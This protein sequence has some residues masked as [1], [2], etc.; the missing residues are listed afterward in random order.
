MPRYVPGVGNLQPKLMIIGES[1]GAKEDEL[2]LPFQGPSGALLDEALFEAGIRRSDCYITNVVKY[3]PPL[4][5]VKKYH[6]AGI[7][8][9][10]CIKELWENE[11]HI[12]RPNCILAI[13]DLALSAVTG[14]TGILLYRGSILHSRDGDFK[15]VPTIH[16][17]AL[18]SRAKSNE[19]D[20]DQS[21][22][23]SW[24]WWKIIKAD[25][26]R[27]VEES[28]TSEFNLPNRTLQVIH[29]SLDLYRF[30]REYEGLTDCTIDIE[31]I[32]CVPSCIGFAFNRHHAVSVPLLTHIGPHKLTDMGKH[33]MNEIWRIVDTQLRKLQLSGHNLMYDDYKLG[34]IGMQLTNVK[35]DT[36][37]K[38]RVIFPELP[39]KK[40]HVVSSIWTREPFYKDEG[41]EFKLGKS[42]ISQHLL[43]NAKDC[44]VEREVDEEQEKDLIL[45][46]ECYRVPARDYY[47]K[48]QMKKHK[49]YLKMSNTGFR[50]D[51]IKRSELRKRYTEMQNEVHAKLVADIGQEINV[52]SYPQVYELL[53]KIMKLRVMKKDPT[54]EDTIVRLMGNHVKK[55]EHKRTLT[56]LLEERRIRD[57]KS[58]YINFAADYDG[59]CK[60]S[61]NIIATETC[62]SSTSVPKKPLRPKKIGQSFH[63]ISK[64]GRLAKDIRSMF[65]VDSGKVFIQAD[66]GQAEARVVAVLCEDW[67]LLSAFDRIDIHRRTAGLVFGFT[68][69]LEL[70]D[71]C[72]N[73]LVDL[74]SKDGI[75]RFTGKKTRHAGNYDMGKRRLMTEYNTDCQKYEIDSSISEWTAGKYLEAFHSA[76]PKIRGKFHADIKDAIDSNR[77][78]I[79]PFGGVRVFCGRMDNELYKEAYANLPQRTVSHL[80]QGA[81][82]KVYEELNDNH[83]VLWISE[84]HDSL[85]I[86]APAENWEPYAKLLKKHMSTPIDFSIYC[87]L[88]RDYKLIIPCDLEVSDTNYAELRKVKI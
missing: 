87:T 51:E 17:A 33:E 47:Y 28:L 43:Y 12:L 81:A 20:E 69:E 70:S 9:D 68:K 52:K 2:G 14:H 85:L 15:C 86:E 38:T 62:R 19:E 80:V 44:A 54:S 84:N 5:D 31:S 67:K 73:N 41:K 22:A 76:S 50:I 66:S 11:I 57:Q 60:T 40:L 29:N 35:S 26:K 27:A 13:G 24:V 77:V 23:L 61:F 34:L 59:R 82:L 21:G 63:T 53:Y 74:L 7:N 58:R 56:N 83:E 36:L 16:M 79:D 37:I 49:F 8:V 30:F 64:H 4:G 45:M 39:I 6:I 46:E 55:A 65:I 48:Y 71:E 10:D 42:P 3:R 88:K 78:L 25:I 1:P 72:S 18:F 75:E 32:N